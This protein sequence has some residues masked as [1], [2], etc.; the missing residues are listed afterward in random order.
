MLPELTMWLG[1]WWDQLLHH[2]R[3]NP[4]LFLGIFAVKSPLWWWTLFLI[5]GRAR[6]QQWSRL[7][8]LIL[9]NVLLNSSPWVYVYL[10]GR[11]LPG[12]YGALLL[13][14]VGMA[15]LWVVFELRKRLRAW[16]GPELEPGHP[17]SATS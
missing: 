4:L 11:N 8:G 12:W 2:H 13:A 1:G 16:P 17:S 9:A 15:M 5:V 3:V 10:V 6:R 14:W 7:P